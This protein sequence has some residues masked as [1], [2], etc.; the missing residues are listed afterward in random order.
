MNDIPVSYDLASERAV[1]GAILL[2][3]HTLD[4]VREI[5]LDAADFCLDVH[6]L[7]FSTLLRLHEQREPMDLITLSAALRSTG[8]LEWVGG[9]ETLTRIF[10]ESF[11]AGNALRYAKLVRE[12][13]IL[14]RM[15][16]ACTD[17]IE[18]I[19]EGVPDLQ[20]FLNEAEEK[21]LKLSEL[22][23]SNRFLSMHESMIGVMSHI[24]ENAATDTDLIGIPTGFSDLDQLIGGMQKTQVIVVAARP[25]MGKTSFIQSL[26][27]HA[28]L[29]HR[30][31]VA[32]FSLEMSDLELS[33]RLIS[34]VTRINSRRLKRGQLSIHE[35][36][37][38][39]A[40]MDRLSK[41][42]LFIDPSG[43]LSVVDI[44][45]RCRRL[46]QQQKR[47]DLVVVDYL[48][49]IGPST[50]MQKARASEVQTLTEISKQ[51]KELAKELQVPIVLLSQLNRP[52]ELAQVKDHRPKLTNL[53]GSGSIEQDADIVLLIHREDYY[54]P[55]S[56]SRGIAEIIVAKNR[57]G[58]QG[59]VKLAWLGE[60]TMFDNL[61]EQQKRQLPV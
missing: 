15:K 23:N 61:T 57:H 45:S 58:E 41:S 3:N 5:G 24:E 43:G 28:A 32:L 39:A 47:L 11:S 6:G 38:L 48:Q 26:V 10:D 60:Y 52:S 59:T 54:D 46:M 4:E 1:I 16:E 49:L 30:C 33:T 35:R 20:A 29:D 34:G 18:K 17:L 56:K 50:L 7:L 19:H 31:V 12:Q 9:T 36:Q 40:G 22:Q 13:A 53:R 14:R 55:Q 44:R 51:M 21:I 42:R 25:G 8:D 37:K 27:L 2:N